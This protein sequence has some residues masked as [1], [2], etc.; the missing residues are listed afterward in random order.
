MTDLL[1]GTVVGFAVA[2]GLFWFFKSKFGVAPEK[3]DIS[4]SLMQLKAVGELVAFKLIT[5][6]I[7][8]AEQHAAGNFGKNWL[9][10][11]LSTKKLAMVIEYEMNFKYNLRDEAFVIREAG[12]DGYHITMPPC[13]YQTNIRNIKFYDETNSRWLP[14]LLGD[15]TEA[16]GAGFSEEDKNRLLE[17]ARREA[18]SKA[19]GL[20]DQLVTEVQSSARQTMATLREQGII[21]LCLHDG[22]RV[23]KAHAGALDEAKDAAFGDAISRLAA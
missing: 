20:A 9:K 5:Q 12:E 3:P 13:T 8:T 21:A 2:I 10:W 11:L 18:D 7:V 1:I 14:W 17:E 23:Q 15:V 16:L 22:F 6:Q 19:T 4:H